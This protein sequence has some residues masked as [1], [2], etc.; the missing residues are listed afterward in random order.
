[1]IDEV[2]R[3]ITSFQKRSS[4]AVNDAGTEETKRNTRMWADAQRDGRP[5]EYK[6]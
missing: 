5:T 4:L 2:S 6:K 3:H 1:L